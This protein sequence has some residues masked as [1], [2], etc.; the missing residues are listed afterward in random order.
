[1][2]N[3]R[4]QTR[5]ADLLVTQR[6]D[7]IQASGLGDGQAPKNEADAD[8]NGEAD[9]DGPTRDHGFQRAYNRDQHDDGAAENNSD[10]AARAGQRHGLEKKLPGDIFA[11]GADGFAY[12]D[13]ASA[14]GDGYQHDIHHAHSANQQ[15]D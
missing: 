3:Y 5:Y 6:L 7:R 14:F 12:T 9:D 13:F 2:T 1:M 15:A 10:Q 4:S 8:G 11:T